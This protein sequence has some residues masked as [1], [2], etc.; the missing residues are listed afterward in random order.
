MDY[1]APGTTRFT[2]PNCGKPHSF[3]PYVDEDG[4][5]VDV[6]KYGRCNH[7]SRC[8]YHLYPPYQRSNFTYQKPRQPDVF[9]E[10]EGADDCGLLR[11]HQ[12]NIGIDLILEQVLAEQALGES[13]FRRKQV[14]SLEVGVHPHYRRETV[15]LDAVAGRRVVWDDFPAAA[16]S[17]DVKLKKDGVAFGSC[18]YVV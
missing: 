4:V 9:G 14:R 6:R 5:P 10:K 1:N 18:T 8:G 12:C 11:L 2:C 16:A 3:A 17:V 7:E 15:I 13:P